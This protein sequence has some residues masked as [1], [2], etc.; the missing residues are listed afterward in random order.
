MADAR[1]GHSILEELS[2]A[3]ALPNAG[4]SDST[5]MVEIPGSSGRKKTNSGLSIFVYANTDITIAT[6]QKFTIEVETYTSD[7]ASSARPPFWYKS[8]GTTTAQAN[9]HWYPLY[10]D[11]SDGE[12]KFS[13]GD[14]ICEIPIPSKQI[15]KDDFIH[16]KYTTDADESSEKVDA[17]LVATL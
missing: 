11:S 3:Q 1:Y 14:L 10:K 4:T 8:S 17:F 2:D 7:S 16:L 6:A 12:L 9:C 5:N 13:A 15:Y